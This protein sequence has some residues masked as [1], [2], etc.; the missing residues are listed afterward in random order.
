M[1]RFKQV[2]SAANY[3]QPEVAFSQKTKKPLIKVNIMTTKYKK[4][5]PNKQYL[6]NDDEN[7]WFY[8]KFC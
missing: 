6:C 7:T 2:V 4:L 8:E 5:I 1:A 3:Q